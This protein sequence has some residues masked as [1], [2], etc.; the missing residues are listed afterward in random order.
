[1]IEEITPPPL[2]VL[3]SRARLRVCLTIAAYSLGL[4]G[5]TTTTGAVV[6]AI[7]SVIR[8]TALTHAMSRWV[9]IVPIAVLAFVYGLHEIGIVYAPILE[10]H[11]QVPVRW[12]RYG[13][14]PQGLLYGVV[15]GTDI[16]TLVPYT[17]LYT[18]LLLEATLGSRGGAVIGL[19]YGL[20]RTTP[21]IAGII[22]S[23]HR[24]DTIAIAMWIRGAQR[25]FHRM[26][27]LVLVVVGQVLIGA[28]L[29]TQ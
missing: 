8:G 21:T 29:L 26:N 23:W 27:G 10:I 9:G 16:F 17:T 4:I 1:M 6:G 20:A 14:V 28:L 2:E 5:S 18:L 19:V 24:R 3:T 22:F 25:W 13:K 15:L 12:A 7:G 11:W